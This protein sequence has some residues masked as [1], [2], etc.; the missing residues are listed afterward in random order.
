DDDLPAAAERKLEASLS[1][2]EV[3]SDAAELSS[4]GF[5]EAAAGRLGR[6]ED[7]TEKCVF[8]A[9]G[10]SAARPRGS[11][12]EGEEGGMADEAAGTETVGELLVTAPWCAPAGS[13]SPAVW[14]AAM[15]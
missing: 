4:A 13:E 15:G 1:V 6:G 9:A 10:A 8:A 2:G 14:E 5:I 12:F 7:E 3:V 11:L